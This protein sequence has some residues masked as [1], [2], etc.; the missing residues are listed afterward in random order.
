VQTW[1]DEGRQ[2]AHGA[3]LTSCRGP[4]VGAADRSGGRFRFLT[5]ATGCSTESGLL[6]AAPFCR[7]RRR[8][9]LADGAGTAW[10]D[11]GEG[12]SVGV[13]DADQ[14]GGA[15]VPR[16]CPRCGQKLT[17]EFHRNATWGARAAAKEWL[18]CPDCDWTGRPNL[19]DPAVLHQ[20]RRLTDEWAD[21]VFCGWENDSFASET[22][23]WD[24]QLCEWHVCLACGRENVRRIG[25]APR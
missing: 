2:G 6:P 3:I 23:V 4:A 21:C 12:Q 10:T 17:L 9:R 5:A 22:F 8:H 14:D 24:D 11:S 18:T 20:F 7:L 13:E 15:T 25:P 19:K 1:A 16:S